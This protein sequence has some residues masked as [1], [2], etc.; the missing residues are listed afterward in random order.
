MNTSL[1]PATHSRNSCV[2]WRTSWDVL[3][4]KIN[5]PYIFPLFFFKNEYLKCPFLKFWLWA[6]TWQCYLI[7]K[8]QWS[9]FHLFFLSKKKTFQF[10]SASAISRHFLFKES[11][12]LLCLELYPQFSAHP[13]GLRWVSEAQQSA[14]V[15]ASGTL[16]CQATAVALAS[17]A[18]RRPNLVALTVPVSYS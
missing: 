5:V 16:W 14:R 6:D 13:L 9:C 2:L 4:L 3:G 8:S 17:S 11:A 12:V 10:M 18:P 15:L 1:H 7:P